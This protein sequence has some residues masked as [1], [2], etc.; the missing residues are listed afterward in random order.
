MG[1]ANLAVT[2]TAELLTY[3]MR[4]VNVPLEDIIIS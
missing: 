3:R 1:A 4:M 2:F